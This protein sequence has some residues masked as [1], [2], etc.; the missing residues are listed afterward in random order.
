MNIKFWK[1]EEEVKEVKTE[2]KT[3]SFLFATDLNELGII[4]VKLTYPSPYRSEFGNVL[5]TQILFRNKGEFDSRSFFN[6]NISFDQHEDFINKLSKEIKC[7][8]VPPQ[9]IVEIK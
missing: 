1:K 8:V 5:A 9:P 4:S 7:I 2:F 3:G 6:Y